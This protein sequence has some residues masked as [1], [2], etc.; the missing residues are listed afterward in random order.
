MFSF[1]VIILSH[2]REELLSKCLDSLRSSAENWQLILVTNEIGLSE[3]M[4]IKARELT[5]NCV[6]HKTDNMLR[7]GKARNEALAIAEGEW[8]FFVDD[9]AYLLPNYWEQILPLLDD[10]KFDVIG[11]PDAIPPGMNAV[12]TSLGLALS[13]P[14]CTGMTHNRHKASGT[15]IRPADEEWFTSCNLWIRK[16]ALNEHSFPEDFVKAE[17]SYLLQKLKVSGKH[18]FYHP[19]LKVA[20]YRSSKIKDLIRPAYS[21]GYSRSKLIRRRIVKGNEAFWLPSLFVLLH[22]TLFFDLSSFL[23]L[24]RMYASIILFVSVTLSMKIKRTGLFPM[25][26]LMHYLV[27][28]LF[29]IGFM[30]ERLEGMRN[31][32]K[33]S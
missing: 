8:L 23:Y 18:L 2:G 11:G 10:Q 31:I 24:A 28:F 32:Q 14:F 5:P 22:L 16:S 26:A 1:T 4:T 12:S 17:E 27:V 3:E 7:P 30:A 13:S 33:S 6:F 9:D 20:H 25:V 21:A 29:G 15:K 19:K